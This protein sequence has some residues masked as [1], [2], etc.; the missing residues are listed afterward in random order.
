MDPE[1]QDLQRARDIGEQ[2]SVAVDLYGAATPFAAASTLAR[3]GQM[4]GVSPLTVFQGSPHRFTKLDSSKIGTGEGVQAYGHGLYF[5]ENK[6][7]AKQYAISRGVPDIEGM[8]YEQGLPK[9]S[10]DARD[11]LMRQAR[12]DK[13]SIEAAK[14]LQSANREVRNMD[15]N[16]LAKVIDKYRG[17]S[18]GRLYT[19]DLPDQIID[20]MLDWDKPLKEQSQ[21]VREHVM[22]YMNIENGQLPA[23]MYVMKDVRNKYKVVQDLPALPGGL[24]DI[25]RTIVKGPDRTNPN[26][27]I[28]AYFNNLKGQD[29]YKTMSRDLGG[30]R[31][32]S[33]YLQL[34]NIPGI[35]YFDEVSRNAGQ[36]TRNFVVFPGEEDA[37]TI[38]SSELGQ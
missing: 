2:A 31:E 22:R 24:F 18:R 11:E 32:A 6:D 23:D 19:I 34:F 5:A 13:N 9:V 17:Q 4:M 30:D 1:A 15:R 38:L 25:P 12:T 37:I 26:E 36:G 8:M 35:K 33:E 16:A 20:R 10:Q 27:A 29:V 3:Q 21:T 7:V 28:E 14:Y